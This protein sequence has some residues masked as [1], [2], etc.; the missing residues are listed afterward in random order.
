MGFKVGDKVLVTAPSW[1]EECIV[2]KMGSD[3]KI[4]FVR[5]LNECKPAIFKSWASVI[6][7]KN[8]QLLFDFMKC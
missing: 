2:F 1:C 5:R 4:M 3:S 8:Q 7:P 6:R